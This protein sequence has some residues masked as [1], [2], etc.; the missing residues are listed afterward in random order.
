[1]PTDLH[2]SCVICYSVLWSVACIITSIYDKSPYVRHIMQDIAIKFLT[3]FLQKHVSRIKKASPV[4]MM[5]FL[6]Y[7]FQHFNQFIFHLLVD[8][9]IAGKCP[10]SLFVSAQCSDQIRVF[11]PFVEV[12]HK[13]P[14][15]KMRRCSLPN[16]PLLPLPGQRV[17]YLNFPS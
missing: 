13:C 15:G 1:M 9:P 4:Q 17:Q 16:R 14:T 10:A 2:A 3:F 6:Y 12:P 7:L 11:H 8:V 5:L